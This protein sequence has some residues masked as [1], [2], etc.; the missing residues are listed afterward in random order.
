VHQGS[1]TME[2]LDSEAITRTT[3]RAYQVPA[4]SSVYGGAE[5]YVDR[6]AEADSGTEISADLFLDFMA[7]TPQLT[8][9]LP[10]LLSV[11]AE[12]VARRWIGV[13]SGPPLYRV[14]CRAGLCAY[15][16]VDVGSLFRLTHFAG[17]TVSG[18]LN[19][20]LWCESMA[21]DIDQRAVTITALDVTHVYE[22]ARTLEEIIVGGSGMSAP[23]GGGGGLLH[24]A[25]PSTRNGTVGSTVYY[26]VVAVFN[27]SEESKPLIIGPFTTTAAYLRTNIF[28]TTYP[29]AVQTN[30]TGLAV[31]P[32][33]MRLYRSNDASFLTGVV[34]CDLTLYP[35][36][37][38]PWNLEANSASAGSETFY[39]AASNWYYL[40]G[41]GPKTAD[42]SCSSPATP[43]VQVL[44][45]DDNHIDEVANAAQFAAAVY[46]RDDT[47]TWLVSGVLDQYHDTG[48]AQNAGSPWV[49]V[50][51]GVDLPLTAT[52]FY[53]L[54]P[55]K[56]DE[57]D[58]PWVTP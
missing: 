54:W 51:P 53:D 49:A 57:A 36:P 34:K 50:T 1:L 7:A 5:T 22:G 44:M 33:A 25:S 10:T 15:E 20:I 48:G 24:V 31:T 9:P 42:E 3:A 6:Q 19:R 28:W 13:R 11:A 16:A 12:D 14:S 30:P 47:T 29:T 40:V 52:S 58:N 23:T 38:S 21:L 2:G 45:Q 39:Y 37:E 56:A 55:G 46:G 43:D 32:T 27:S 41:E 17:T 35:V 26:K 4:E 18:Y 8:G